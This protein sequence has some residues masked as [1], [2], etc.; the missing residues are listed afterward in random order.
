MPAMNGWDIALFGGAAYIAVIA[1]V[2]LMRRYHDRR[3]ADLRQHVEQEKRRLR[4]K[5]QTEQQAA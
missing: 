3:Q 4:A 2:R 5:R 1:L